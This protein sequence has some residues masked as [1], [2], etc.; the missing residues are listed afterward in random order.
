MHA[1]QTN[2]KNDFTIHKS[3]WS[4]MHF[5]GTVLINKYKQQNAVLT[6]DTENKCFN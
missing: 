2:K 3:I 5:L 1:K 4:K 6:G